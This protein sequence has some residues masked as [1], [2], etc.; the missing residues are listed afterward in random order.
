MLLCHPGSCPPCPK[1]VSVTCYCGKQAPCPRRC[2]AKEWSCGKPCNKKYLICEHKCTEKCH[3]GM[4]PP[5]SEK[6][7]SA[8]N[9]KNKSELRKCNDSFWFCDKICGRQYSCNVHICE[10]FCHKPGDC[11]KCPLESNRTCPCGK[12]KYAISCKQQQVPTC[13]DTCGKLLDC[14]A[15]YC[16]MR[17]HT[18]RCGQCL[19]VVTK[20]CRCGSFSKEIPCIKEFHC[21]KKCPQMRLCGIHL[22][23]KK[24]CDCLLQN[25]FNVCEK[26]CDNTLNCR[27][28]KC[29]A[30]CH[31]GP[32]YPCPRTIDIQCRCGNNKITIPC[33][34]IKKIKPPNC[35]KKCKIAP[36]CHHPK[37]E[38]HKCHQGVCPPCPKVCELIHKRC[39]HTCRAICHT[40]VWM[41]IKP[42]GISKPIGPW[43][44]QKERWEYKSFPCP[45][46]EISVMVTCL[47][48]HETLTQPCHK[49]ISASCFRQCGQLL[50]C[51]NHK[52]EKLCHKLELLDNDNND[53][54]KC[55][56]CEK[57]CVLLRPKGCTHICPK[58]C[59]PAPCEPCTQL[60]KVP[61][62]CGINILYVRC[63]QLTSATLEKRKEL[64]LCGNQCPRN[65]RLIVT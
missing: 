62:H 8:C 39:N 15:H 36:I 44:N 12:M 60:V 54:N 13:G 18:E 45:P 47:G 59:H 35:N 34:T 17:C 14:G 32:C 22:C 26:V 65:V 6:K 48:G 23:N 52:C 51:T 2:N 53:Q 21:N 38:S 3:S 42:N 5:C 28:H 57:S 7:L 25:N 30:P 11:N 9:C 64:L 1:M 4:C 63:A 31:R 43:E 20:T 37:R 46:C 10:S 58:F 56:V 61:C 40:K 19:E 27:K 29:S 55:M 16:N 33:G 24:C 49:A 50:S 41:K